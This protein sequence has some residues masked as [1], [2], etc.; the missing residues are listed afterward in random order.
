VLQL[1]EPPLRSAQLRFATPNGIKVDF[2]FL[3][4]CRQTYQEAHPTPYTRN[5]F[6]FTHGH[7]LRSLMHNN[8]QNT[9]NFRSKCVEIENCLQPMAGS[10]M[11]TLLQ[12]ASELKTL[13]QLHIA[14]CP[15]IGVGRDSTCHGSGGL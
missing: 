11:D 13:R 5:T 9:Q 8:Q 10:W 12:A 7:V 2:R 14:L 3:R 4:T 1:E 6:S 15:G